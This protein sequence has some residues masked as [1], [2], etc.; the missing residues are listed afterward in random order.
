[1]YEFIF[2]IYF[3]VFPVGQGALG[4]NGRMTDEWWTQI[5]VLARNFSGQTEGKLPEASA[6]IIGASVENTTEHFA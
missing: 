3:T 2:V 5:A 6:R 4:S 1:M